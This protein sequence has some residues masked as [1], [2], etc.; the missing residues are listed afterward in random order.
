MIETA[1]AAS[2][3]DIEASLARLVRVNSSGGA[4]ANTIL[5]R[6]VPLWDFATTCLGPLVADGS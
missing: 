5:F 6:P 4:A 3:S 1:E 2:E